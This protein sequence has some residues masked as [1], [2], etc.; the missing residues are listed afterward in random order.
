MSSVAARAN[1]FK[2]KKMKKQK[3][4][5]VALLSF[6]L[7]VCCLIFAACGDNT[8]SYKIT[9][10]YANATVAATGYDALPEEAKEGTEITFTV[11][12][13]QGYQV[14]S[15]KQGKAT[16]K[17][18]NGAYTF[19]VSAD[20]E[21]TVT[22]TEILSSITVT[23]PTKLTYYAGD[24]LDKTGMS[25]T[26]N[27]ATGK[28][29]AVTAYTVAYNNGSAFALGDTY[30]TVSYGGISE[31]V[32]LSGAVKGLVTVDLYGG[33]LSDDVLNVWKTY[34]DY[35]CNAETGVITWTFDKAFEADFVLPS[36]ENVS[37][38]VNGNE[39]PFNSWTGVSGNKI[40]KGTDTSVSVTASYDPQLLEIAALQ[41]TTETVD[42]TE[43]PYLII[44]GKFVAATEAYLYLYEGNHEV[45][46]NGPTVTKGTTN[47]FVL[48]F[49][50]REL[51]AA[52]YEG[53]KY[54]GMWMDIKFRASFG[55]RI[56]TQEINL[57]NYADDF[58]DTDDMLAV[59]IDGAW[60]KFDY[61]LYPVGGGNYLKLEYT[62][63]TLAET[64]FVPTSAK[65]EIREVEGVE[66]PYLVVNGYIDA[67]IDE[68]TAKAGVETLFID[69]T[70]KT[71]GYNTIDYTKL[72]TSLGDLSF[73]VA[74]S[75]DNATDGMSLFSHITAGD[76]NNFVLSESKVESG[77]I[78]IGKMNY[79]LC[80][81][82]IWGSNLVV[83]NVVDSTYLINEITLENKN[84]TPYFVISGT[85]GSWMS[86]SEAQTFIE[87]SHMIVDLQNNDD[88]NSKGWD[89][90]A[91][92]DGGKWVEV[93]DGAFK[94]Y[95][96]LEN[97]VIGNALYAHVGDASTNFTGTAITDEVLT[98]GGLKYSLGIYTGW[99]SN[100]VTIYVEDGRSVT[101]T[102]A[103][104][105][106]DGDNI[107]VVISG[108]YDNFESADDFKAVDLYFDFQ[109][110]PY[111]LTG[112][113]GGSW[114]TYSNLPMEV[115]VNNDGTFTVKIDITSL[116]AYAYTGHFGLAAGTD[117]KIGKEVEREKVFA[118]KTYSLVSYPGN[119]SD[120]AKF[121]SCLGLVI[122]ED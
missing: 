88:I 57:N 24:M 82:R 122:T 110:N 23:K 8:A 90:I 67:N 42:E 45:E 94:I 74:L 51:V 75:L 59:E 93:S 78:S 41:F 22:L 19:T 86:E 107:Y 14:T 100:L 95:V 69:L 54:E 111:Y 29:E 118:G 28:T 104:F 55:D 113:W 31:K 68:E 76:G 83:V 1:K 77:T 5:L 4:A 72:V 49:D 2:E 60:Y 53:E 7:S 43:V 9:W 39:F 80:V 99:S 27:Y 34:P 114:T 13:A 112:D 102:D 10:S 18:S 16:L 20:T 81:D 89:T 97:A 65:L 85:Y 25:V 66:V 121:W 61:Q 101:P 6:V 87:E 11:T 58:V 71:T 47:D 35:S 116:E 15:V 84:D 26:A 63:G 73:E 37:K 50:L 52:E 33:E 120:G 17:E 109:E 30:F 70:S 12:P 44:T 48:K 98:I 105:E 92:P 38:V 3:I 96:S 21:I 79:T 106:V 91:I 64:A 46:L 40:A 115:T 103:K 117:C 119:D 32:E 62:S 56:E 108:T 36:A